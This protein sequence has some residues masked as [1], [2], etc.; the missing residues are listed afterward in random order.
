M[1]SLSC[2]FYI[3][4]KTKYMPLRDIVDKQEDV[5]SHVKTLLL[6]KEPIE[7][8]FSLYCFLHSGENGK[9]NC[10]SHINFVLDVKNVKFDH[11]GNPFNLKYK[12]SS[13]VG[14]HSHDLTRRIFEP[15]YKLLLFLHNDLKFFGS[16][17][18]VKEIMS[19][20]AKKY[21]IELSYKQCYYLRDQ[22]DPLHEF[23]DAA[24]FIKYL[25]E[26]DFN[27]CYD[28]DDDKR[29]NF[30]VYCSDFQKYVNNEYG[31]VLF[32]DT[33]VQTNKYNLVRGAFILQLNNGRLLPVLHCLIKDQ[34]KETFIKVFDIAFTK[35]LKAPKTIF[36]DQDQAIIAAINHCLKNKSIHLLCSRHAKENAEKNIAALVSPNAFTEIPVEKRI[37]FHAKI[38]GLFGAIPLEKAEADM[39]YLTE[40]L[41]EGQIKSY[42]L[43]LFEKKSLSLSSFH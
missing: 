24:D 28:L 4:D 26:K 36:T 31:S 39:A 16:N 40:E 7:Y 35:F 25:Y 6:E 43:K 34:T 14:E 30:L 29:L 19:F 42:V 32:F 18:S 1:A 27:V 2:Y 11:N 5:E 9:R 21:Q 22:L 12:R 17:S 13:I 23:G 33:I 8:S 37:G 10:K 20:A 41:P 3:L 15:S 38:L